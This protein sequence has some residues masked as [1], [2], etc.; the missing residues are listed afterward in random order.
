MYDH[1]MHHSKQ[2]STK[3]A[4]S[5]DSQ[6]V[7]VPTA[8]PQTPCLLGQ[9]P[10]LAPWGPAGIPTEGTSGAAAHPELLTVLSLVG[11]HEAHREEDEEQSWKWLAWRCLVPTAALGLPARE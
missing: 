4:N 2:A 7:V 10:I 1:S 8:L 11:Q 5:P 9:A 3:Q 6:Q